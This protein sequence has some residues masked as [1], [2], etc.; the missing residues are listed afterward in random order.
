MQRIKKPALNTAAYTA[1]VNQLMIDLYEK[2][3]LNKESEKFYYPV[4]YA[5]KDLAKK[6]KARWDAENKG[7]YFLNEESLNAFIDYEG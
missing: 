3:K 5:E 2:S 4:D 1:Y 6:F 7:W